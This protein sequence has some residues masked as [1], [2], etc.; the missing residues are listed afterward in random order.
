MRTYAEILYLI[1]SVLFALNIAVRFYGLGW[2]SY[3]ADGW[4]F[5]EV[6]IITGALTT[7]CLRLGGNEN[8]GLLQLQKASL[9]M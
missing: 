2:R 5:F 6:F 7:T 1:V 9:R 3:I 8:G 4:N